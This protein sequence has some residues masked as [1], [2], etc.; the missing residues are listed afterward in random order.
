MINAAK[1]LV[2]N[3]NEF[4]IWKIRIE[5]YFL[6]T[7]YALWEVIL[8]GDSPPPTRSVE[9]VETPY[10][11]TT[12]EEKLSM[13][14]KLKAR[15]TLLTYLPNEHKLKFKSYKNAKSLME[16]IEKRFGGNKESKKVHKTLL[17]QQ[18]NRLKVA[19]GN[20]DYE[21]QKIPIENRKESRTSKHQDNR[22]KEAPKRT[23]PFKLFLLWVSQDTTLNALVSQCNGLG[24]DWS[25]QAKDGPTNFALI[26]HTSLSSSSSLNS[27]TKVSTCS[28]VCL[29]SYETLKEY[30][31]NLTKD[32]NKSQFNL[33][34]HKA[35]LESVEARL[36]VYKKNKAIFID[37]IKILK[38]DVMLRDKAITKLR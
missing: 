17:K 8:N 9:S 23:M 26:A 27:D 20:V 14:N 30:Y 33:G 34:A 24:Y 19:D 7:D 37:D 32:F 22:N 25:Y 21:S 10:P 28:K 35:G 5:Q 36:E 11:P 16:A 18:G 13:K 29:K 31:D 38:L 1:L 3:P 4:E 2:L 6:M 12:I 15:G